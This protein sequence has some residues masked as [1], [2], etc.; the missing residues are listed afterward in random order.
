VYIILCTLLG[1]IIYWYNWAF[2]IMLVKRNN[3]ILNLKSFCLCFSIIATFSTCPILVPSLICRPLGTNHFFN[4]SKSL[5]LIIFFFFNQKVGIKELTK[6]KIYKEKKV[7][8]KEGTR[9]KLQTLVTK[10]K[11]WHARL[12]EQE[13]IPNEQRNIRPQ[14]Q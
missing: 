14:T 2:S 4:L 8:T 5:S 11:R 6:P 12:V 13:T 9:P 3:L 1:L 7:T 10:S